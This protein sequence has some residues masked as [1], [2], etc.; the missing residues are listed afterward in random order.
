MT[1]YLN[2]RFDETELESKSLAHEHVGVVT[3][4]EGVLEFL[5][6][7]TGEVGACASPLAS[8]IISITLA[9]SLAV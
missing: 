5:Q 7:P 8:Y 4:V 3:V 6:L 1:V 9:P 2:A